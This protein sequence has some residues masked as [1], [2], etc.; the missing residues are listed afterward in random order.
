[1]ASSVSSIISA[2]PPAGSPP[3]DEWTR[4]HKAKTAAVAA[5]ASSEAAAK[6]SAPQSTPVTPS[7]TS[8][9]LPAPTATDKTTSTAAEQPYANKSSVEAKIPNNDKQPENPFARPS[10]AFSPNIPS[11]PS[12]NYVPNS[13]PPLPVSPTSYT[14]P[15]PSANA[16]VQRPATLDTKL[17]PSGEMQNLA[18]KVTTLEN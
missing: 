10:S 5:R 17:Q 18:N 14:Q 3:I 2:A 16:P 12:N 15:I 8:A 9:D 1:M 11:L 13:D 4:D 7:A 6:K